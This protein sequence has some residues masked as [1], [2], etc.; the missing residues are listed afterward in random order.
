VVLINLATG[1]AGSET[2]QLLGALILG[3]IWATIQARTH[4][5][6]ERRHPTFL[7]ID[8]FADIL[9]LP[10]DL[11]EMLAKTRGY[12]VSM[13]LGHQHLAQLPANIRSAVAA[14]LR[15]RIAFQCGY[16]D[17]A[18]LAKVM[19]GGLTGDD[20][21]N[22]PRFETYQVLCVNGR[23]L[24]PASA[25]TLP[26]SRPLGTLDEVRALSRQRYGVPREETDR[27]LIA[28]RTVAVPDVE[29]GSRRRRIS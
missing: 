28:R 7:V 12:G 24:P 15:S 9:K 4:V 3:R 17:A 26:L 25:T 27:Q 8:E 13:T 29:V 16:D 2:G 21:Q 5:P 1:D 14:N 19:G 6:P 20:I 22:L 23:T 10:G 18:I 11:G